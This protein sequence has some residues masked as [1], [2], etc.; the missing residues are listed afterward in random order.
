MW[1]VRALNVVQSRF[2]TTLSRASSKAHAP[3]RCTVFLR[4]SMCCKLWLHLIAR[5]KAT[6]ERCKGC[7]VSK[8]WSHEQSVSEVANVPV[9]LRRHEHRPCEGHEEMDDTILLPQFRRHHANAVK[10]KKEMEEVETV[11]ARAKVRTA[12]ESTGPNDN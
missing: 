3:S 10:E 4:M 8:L 6:M 2:S 12:T 7:S 5:A 11:R 1:A 9:N